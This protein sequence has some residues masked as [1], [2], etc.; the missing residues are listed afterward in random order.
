MLLPPTGM[1]IVIPLYTVLLS[2]NRELPSPT[3]GRQTAGLDQS[4][5]GEG[6]KRIRRG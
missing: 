2:A 3:T 6:P 4:R 5:R 1:R